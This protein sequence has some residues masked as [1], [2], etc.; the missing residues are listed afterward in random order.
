MGPA[1]GEQVFGLFPA[2][3]AAAK[4]GQADLRYR[5]QA[6]LNLL[7][8]VAKGLDLLLG[9]G[10]RPPDGQKT[11]V[12]DPARGEEAGKVPPPAE[13]PDPVAPLGGP[14]VIVHLLTGADQVAAR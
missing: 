6:R 10:P 13:L 4:V 12:L 7:D 9:F 5:H 14:V 8:V 1:L 3:L 11:S 2:A